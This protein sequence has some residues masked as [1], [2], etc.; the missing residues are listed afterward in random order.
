[1]IWT[2][3]SRLHG[4]CS[5]TVLQPRCW[6]LLQPQIRRWSLLDQLA[7]KPTRPWTRCVCESMSAYRYERRR[8]QVSLF[9][10]CMLAWVSL[11]GRSKPRG[12]KLVFNSSIKIITPSLA[13][14]LE[15]LSNIRWPTCVQLISRKRVEWLGT[16][17]SAESDASCRCRKMSEWLGF[18]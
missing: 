5:N 11:R 1:M 15:N 18:F 3:T 8:V 4:V 16:R 14:T 13:W 6:M 17:S 12:M 2:H 7:N 9:R 10:N